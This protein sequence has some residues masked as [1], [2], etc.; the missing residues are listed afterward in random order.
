L[1]FSNG[2]S[3]CPISLATES[4]AILNKNGMTAMY[5]ELQRQSQPFRQQNLDLVN[6]IK[7]VFTAMLQVLQTR[8]E[9][10]PGDMRVKMKL[11]AKVLV[12]CAPHSEGGESIAA[13]AEILRE[14]IASAAANPAPGS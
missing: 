10:V 3:G 6:E 1:L 11:L 14:V 2:C 8:P 5:Q 13:L 7:T 9:V 12:I 4:K